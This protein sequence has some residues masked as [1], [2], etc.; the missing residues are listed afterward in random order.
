MS[1]LISRSIYKSKLL[2]A[3]DV[4]N[5]EYREAILNE[6]SDLILAIQNQQSAYMLALR[7]LDN[8][9]TA[10]DV[11]KVV[12]EFESFAKLAE[13]R[14][15]NGTSE[16]AYQE[17]KCCVKAIEI[18]KQEAEQYQSSEIGFI[19]KT[20]VLTLIEEI[21]C[22]DDIPKNYGTLLDIMRMI[23]NM[24]TVDN[25]DNGWIPC[26][27]RLPEESGYYLVTYHNWSDGNFLPK[28]NDTYARKLHYQISDHFVGWNYPK[29][30][31][32]RAEN[33]C[34]KEV[35]A[36]QPLPEPFKERD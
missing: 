13:D 30:V 14:W 10:Y 31:D 4:L 28:Y 2:K 1:D 26:S 16:H 6:D 33:D 3:L 24:P 21:K 34:H 20:E 7:L 18:V 29:N 32:D 35:I 36:W 9:P 11:D 15:T 8:E 5:K 27:E 25:T 17:H 12:Y 22:N 19:S 23:R